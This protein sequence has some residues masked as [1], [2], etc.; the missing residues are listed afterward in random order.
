MSANYTD[1]EAI[2]NEWRIVFLP[3]LEGGAN[4]RKSRYLRRLFGAEPVNLEMSVWNPWERNAIVRHG[5]DITAALEGCITTATETISCETVPTAEDSSRVPS[6]AEP[7]R[8]RNRKFLLIGISWGGV[9]ALKLL[10]RGLVRPDRVLL[11]APALRPLEHA[12]PYATTLLSA[13]LSLV[14]Q[15]WPWANDALFPVQL[16]PES[17]AEA[18]NVEFAKE[19]IGEGTAGKADTTR[20][21]GYNTSDSQQTLELERSSAEKNKNFLWLLHGA[22]DSVVDKSGSYELARRYPDDIRYFEIANGDHR[23]NDALDTRD[24]LPGGKDEPLLASLYN[25]WLACNSS[26]QSGSCSSFLGREQAL[27]ENG[28]QDSCDTS[29]NLDTRSHGC[30]NGKNIPIDVT[31]ILPLSPKSSAPSRSNDNDDGKSSLLNMDMAAS[32]RRGQFIK[33]DHRQTNGPKWCNLADIVVDLC[34][35]HDDSQ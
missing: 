27:Y 1:L 18:K 16:R 17:T 33:Q 9:V 25:S 24:A 7:E 11:I 35:T 22:E 31:E 2:R 19:N 6:G 29:L 30:T 26:Y 20:V 28:D 34:R 5:G 12:Y 14:R 4:G 10:E 15:P 13:T 32:P 8:S 21:E 3:G 23:M